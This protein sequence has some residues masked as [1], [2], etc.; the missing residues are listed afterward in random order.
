MRSWRTVLD[1]E[2]SSTGQKSLAL[3]FASNTL[4]L[5][6]VL[7]HSWP[8]LPTVFVL[9]MHWPWPQH[10]WPWPSTLLASNTPG[11]GFEHTWSRPR[12]LLALALALKV[13]EVYPVRCLQVHLQVQVPKHQVQVLQTCISST[14]STS[15]QTP[16]TTCLEGTI[17]DHITAVLSD[18]EVQRVACLCSVITAEVQQRHRPDHAVAA[19]DHTHRTQVRTTLR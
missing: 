10:A 17:L 16:S 5:G 13:S 15:I 1:H 9:K 19:T 2:N 8:W 18:V 11:L 6:L 14:K 7:E 4:G 12:P 3:A